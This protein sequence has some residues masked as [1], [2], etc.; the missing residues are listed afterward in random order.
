MTET[1]RPK[2]KYKKTKNKISEIKI[3]F[4]A[5]SHACNTNT[6]AH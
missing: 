6:T 1:D 5:F 2:Q 4:D 3:H